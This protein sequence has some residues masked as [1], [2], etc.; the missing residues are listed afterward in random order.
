MGLIRL[1]IICSLPAV[2]FT[3]DRHSEL[4]QPTAA[5]SSARSAW[6]AANASLPRLPITG[7]TQRIGCN[8]PSNAALSVFVHVVSCRARVTGRVVSD[9]ENSLARAATGVCPCSSQPF[10]DAAR[11]ERQHHAVDANGACLPGTRS[12]SAQG[13][14]TWARLF[15]ADRQS[16][17]ALTHHACTPH[18][19]SSTQPHRL[20]TSVGTVHRRS[21]CT[22]H[23]PLV[24]PHLQCLAGG[25]TDCLVGCRGGCSIRLVGRPIDCRSGGPSGISIRLVG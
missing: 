4:P 25:L 6:L 9:S 23:T 22:E 19:R 5:S 18:H 8:W 15:T 21:A 24:T 2:D 17:S 10:Q 20:A 13:C 14:S 3:A 7:I 1:R 11:F 16:P 12:G